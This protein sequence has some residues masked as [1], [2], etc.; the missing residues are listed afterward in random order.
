[1]DGVHD[2][3]GKQGFGP[4]PIDKTDSPFELDWEERMWAMTRSG[5]LTSDITIDWFRHSVECMVPSDYLSY[6]YFEKWIASYFVMLTDNGTLMMDEVLSGK[7]VVKTDPPTAMTIDDALAKNRSAHASFARD[8]ESEPAFAVG[9]TVLTVTH[10]SDGHVR[11]PAYARGRR[12]KVIAYHGGHVDPEKG[13]RGIKEPDH[14]YTISFSAPELWGEG[15]NARDT[16]TLDLW[17]F[18]CVSP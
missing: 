4:I 11:L 13:S 12:G 6:R 15:A 16:V 7:S 1:M 18:Y 14:L 5:G 3:G 9:D 17:E 2:L 8:I 10:T